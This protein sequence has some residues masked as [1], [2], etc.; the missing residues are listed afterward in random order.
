MKW[1]DWG[2]AGPGGIVVIA[3]IARDRCDRK[4]PQPLRSTV[5]AETHANLG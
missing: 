4:D 3:D 1:D 2:G 5:M